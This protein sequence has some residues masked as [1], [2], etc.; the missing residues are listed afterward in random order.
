MDRY[1]YTYI[2][3]STRRG[4]LYIGITNDLV[5][6]TSE[7]KDG[8]VASFTKQYHVNRLVYYDVFDNPAD[9]IG[10]EKQLKRWH[11]EWKINLI[12]ERNPEWKD[13]GEDFDPKNNNVDPETS[14]G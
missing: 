7:H 3:A 1:Y 6:R 4:T 9:A 2:T 13:L 11:R 8:S 14:S 5:R 10:R 12:E